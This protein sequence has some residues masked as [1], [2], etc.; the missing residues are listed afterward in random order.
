MTGSLRSPREQRDGDGGGAA[1]GP[2]AAVVG[3]FDKVAEE[4][5]GTAKICRKTANERSADAGGDDRRSFADGRRSEDLLTGP[6]NVVDLLIGDGAR[7]LSPV[8]E[9]R[10]GAVAAETAGEARNA[11]IERLA[12]MVGRF[13]LVE[14]LGKLAE[15]A[16]HIRHGGEAVA[17]SRCLRPRKSAVRVT[18]LTSVR[19]RPV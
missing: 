13:M 11:L 1:R 12:A 14:T 9:R 7:C 19:V 4:A 16:A 8:V 6:A 3:G 17:A 15:D 5:A 2:D 10:V 18:A